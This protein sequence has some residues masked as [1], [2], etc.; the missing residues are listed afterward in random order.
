MLSSSRDKMK[1]LHIYHVSCRKIFLAG[2]CAFL[3]MKAGA[4]SPENQVWHQY[5]GIEIQN[6]ALSQV[7]NGRLR[8]RPSNQYLVSTLEVASWKITEISK[9]RPYANYHHDC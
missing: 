8:H 6:R 5:P 1:P 3:P 7:V 4:T 2:V 9:S